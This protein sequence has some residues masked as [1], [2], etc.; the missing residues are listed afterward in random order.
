MTYLDYYCFR[1]TIEHLDWYR[2]LDRL[3]D[4]HTYNRQIRQ[5]SLRG[6]IWTAALLICIQSLNCIYWKIQTPYLFLRFRYSL[7]KKTIIQNWLDCNTYYNVI[8]SNIRVCFLL[9]DSNLKFEF[10]DF[11]LW[12]LNGLEILNLKLTLK[13]NIKIAKRRWNYGWICFKNSILL[14]LL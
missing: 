5:L 10:D 4:R 11:Y 3:T 13:T 14:A 9:N 1:A 8:I 7:E 6:S 2:I 12:K